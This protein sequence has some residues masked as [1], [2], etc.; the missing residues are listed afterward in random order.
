MRNLP[1][2]PGIFLKRLCDLSATSSRI[3][4]CLWEKVP[5]R[6][7]C[8][9][10]RTFFPSSKRLPYA[11]SSPV[12]QSTFPSSLN[13]FILSWMIFSTFLSGLKSS[14]HFMMVSKTFLKFS[15]DIAVLGDLIKSS[16]V[17]R[18]RLFHHNS[19]CWYL[20]GSGFCFIRSAPEA[21]EAVREVMHD[22][23]RLSKQA[24]QCAVEVFDSVKNLRRILGF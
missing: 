13:N 11:R 23:S 7:S 1:V 18:R 21:E 8:P 24:R 9:L 20:Y 15:S 2:A 3:I 12:A 19:G 4:A 17:A 14:G 22:W 5:R 10:I 6:T 16:G